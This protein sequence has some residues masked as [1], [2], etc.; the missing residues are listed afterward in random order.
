MIGSPEDALERRAATKLE[1]LH[2]VELALGD[3]NRIVEAQ[4]TERRGPDQADT[5]RGTNQIAVVVLQSQTSSGIR[6]NNAR[7]LRRLDAAGH[8]DLAR[9]RPRRRA[10]VVIQAAGIGIDRSLDPDF[11]RQEP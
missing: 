6:R 3:R 5:D 1:L 2:A 4:R 7:R 8:V 9:L 11:L 10:L